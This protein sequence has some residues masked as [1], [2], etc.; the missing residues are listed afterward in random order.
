[1]LISVINQEMRLGV[2]LEKCTRQDTTTKYQQPIEL[3]ARRNTF[4]GSTELAE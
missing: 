2:K 4:N 3:H 1:M